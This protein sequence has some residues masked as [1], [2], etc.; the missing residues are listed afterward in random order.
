M[1]WSKG[2]LLGFLLAFNGVLL[3]TYVNKLSFAEDANKLLL[4]MPDGELYVY[5]GKRAAEEWRHHS[6]DTAGFLPRLARASE[7]FQGS[8]ETVRPVQPP[9]G[10]SSFTAASPITGTAQDSL[11]NSYREYVQAAETVLS[12]KYLSRRHRLRDSYLRI[13]ALARQRERSSDEAVKRRAMDQIDSLT[14]AMGYPP[15]SRMYMSVN[16]GIERLLEFLDS[17]S[18][19]ADELRLS[20]AIQN[21]DEMLPRKGKVSIYLTEYDLNGLTHVQRRSAYLWLLQAKAEV[22]SQLAKLTRR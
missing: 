8:I 13:S 1:G 14:M 21:L 9:R 5:S 16:A 3:F 11:W 7:L 6:Y 2:L 17:R 15:P 22:D 18:N 10:L 12:A 19:P 4:G 20:A